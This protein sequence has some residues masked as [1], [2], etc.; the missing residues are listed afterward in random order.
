MRLARDE[1]LRWRFGLAAREHVVTNRIIAFF[2]SCE[3]LR[4]YGCTLKVYR[5]PNSS[6]NSR[7]AVQARPSVASKPRRRAGRKL[8]ATA[9]RNHDQWYA[10]NLSVIVLQLSSG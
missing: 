5:E 9:L 1:T 6:M 4:D 3:A 7:A 10:C 2:T 8:E